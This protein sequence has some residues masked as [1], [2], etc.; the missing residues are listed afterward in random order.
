MTW[1]HIAAN[2]A[3]MTVYHFCSALCSVKHYAERCPG[4]ADRISLDVIEKALTRLIKT[5]Q[6]WLR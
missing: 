3:A 5:S 6:I 4:I 2:A 1:L